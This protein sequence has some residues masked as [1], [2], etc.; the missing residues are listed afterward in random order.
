M[1]LE[2]NRLYSLAD[3]AEMTGLKLSNLRIWVN[4]GGIQAQK[5]GRQWYLNY[6]QV[7]ELLGET[8]REQVLENIDLTEIECRIT[9]L[10]ERVTG[11]LLDDED[12]D[13]LLDILES[14]ME[15]ALTGKT[16]P[17]GFLDPDD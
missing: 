11:K 12:R 15:I 17:P 13:E 3:V 4:H 5:V 14:Y 6:T 10:I 8:E 16:E 9:T 7:R 2:R 1:E